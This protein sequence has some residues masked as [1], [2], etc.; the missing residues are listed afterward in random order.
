MTVER[1]TRPARTPGPDRGGSILSAIDHVQLPMPPGGEEMARS[2]YIDI[3]GLAEVEKPPEL[4]ARGGTWFAGRDVAIHLGVE[5][6]H[7][8]SA[9]AHP[10]FI[11]DDLTE[12]RA[13]LTRAGVPVEEDDSGLPVERC[14]IRDPFGNRIELIDA[15]DA[16]FSSGAPG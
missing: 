4:A 2:F 16:G 10:G 5:H 12:T 8:P 11:V 15:G 13:H 14:Y 9:K 1:K 3:L 7:R 6:D